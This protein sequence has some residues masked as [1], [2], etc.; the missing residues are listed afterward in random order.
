MTSYK[1][2]N[3]VQIYTYAKVGRNYQQNDQSQD[4]SYNLEIFIYPTMMA[5][6]GI[7]IDIPIDTRI[8]FSIEGVYGVPTTKRRTTIPDI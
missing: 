5:I 3:Q 6:G 7:K 4:P 8:S 2:S 1:T